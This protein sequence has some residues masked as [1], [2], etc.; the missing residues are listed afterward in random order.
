MYKIARN[1]ERTADAMISD[2]A[3]ILLS[4]VNLHTAIHETDKKQVEKTMENQSWLCQKFLSLY[5]F[6]D[7]EHPTSYERAQTFTKRW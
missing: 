4:K 5:L 3:S 1:Q 7:W 6:F 2:N